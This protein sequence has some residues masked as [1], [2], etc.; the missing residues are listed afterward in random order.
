MSLP[1]ITIITVTYNASQWLERCVESV[2]MQKREGFEIEHLI[3]DG[4]STDGTVELI[5]RLFAAG[6]VSRFVSEKDA[7]I[8]DAMNKGARLAR[9]EVVNFL[10]ADD[11]YLSDDVVAV[12]VAPILAG[13]AAFT[14]S[15]A[16]VTDEEGKKKYTCYPDF[17]YAFGESPFNHQ[18]L[19]H[20]IELLLSVG[21]FDLGFKF[22]ADADFK[23]KL[24][25]SKE[26]YRY[27][28][29]ECICFQ[30]GG[31]SVNFHYD[32]VA[33]LYLKYE[34][35]NI[36][37]CQDEASLPLQLERLKSYAGQCHTKMAGENKDLERAQLAA[38]LFA[39]YCSR[40]AQQ[41]LPAYAGYFRKLAD[42][43]E[44]MA[45]SENR[46]PEYWRLWIDGFRRSCPESFMLTEEWLKIWQAKADE[47]AASD[48]KIYYKTLRKVSNN[49]R[50]YWESDLP[51]IAHCF[52]RWSSPILDC[53]LFSSLR[54]QR[55]PSWLQRQTVKVLTYY[56]AFVKVPK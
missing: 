50:H 10:N 7:G 29:R 49:A 1:L 55:P 44:E 12:M 16:V 52:D 22:S 6:K 47:L 43:L 5:E 2:A 30:A 19:F 4:V 27:I 20:R 36:A 11:Y 56:Y 8:Y 37:V 24:L 54:G 53:V 46:D 15:N 9:G 35:E 31:M 13:D 34:K 14:F 25:L 28:D 21:G 18:T 51:R 40:A 48:K 42:G 23:A 38:E 17:A 41:V 26:P 32:E 39:L 3:V 33:A 45:H